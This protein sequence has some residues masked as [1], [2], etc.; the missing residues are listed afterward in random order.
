M[1]VSHHGAGFRR[2]RAWVG[3][4]F[5]GTLLCAIDRDGRAAGLS[6]CARQW[7]AAS[8]L[9]ALFVHVCAPRAPHD[10]PPTISAVR[11]A[12]D[13]LQGLGLA[14]G[15]LRIV[16]G[17]PAAEL[18][19]LIREER[20]ALV[21]VASSSG[22]DD[23][24]G[25]LCTAVLRGAPHPVAVLPPDGEA[26]FS[27]G[28]IACAV[29]VGHGDE[30]AV[31]FAGALAAASGRRL[32]LTHVVG[33]MDAARLATARMGGSLGE[34]TAGLAPRPLARRLVEVARECDADALVVAA[35]AHDAAPDGLLGPVARGLWTAAPCPVVVVRA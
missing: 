14:D 18:L 28:P 35:R 10:R 27:G 31:R 21:L 6:T 13:D 5:G 16:R 34:Q 30:A 19:S 22:D 20:P 32:A 7:A 24:L 9:R 11:R 33:A 25:S 1:A 3:M 15:E 26:S 23:H 4:E 2:H 8:G 12:H 29:S 17:E